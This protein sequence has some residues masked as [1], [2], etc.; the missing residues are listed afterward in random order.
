VKKIF[1][2]LGIVL[3]GLIGLIVLVV[4]GLYIKTK[5]AFSQTYEVKVESVSVPTDAESIAR[6]QHIVTFLCMECHGDNLGGKPDFLSLPNIITVNTPNL[7]SGKGGIGSGFTDE[8]WVRVLRHGVKPDGTSIF[9]MPAQDF[10]YLNDQDLSAL[11][12]YAKS[13]P[14]VESQVEL[15]H[16]EITFMGKVMYGAG[17]FGNLARASAIDQTHRPVLPEPGLN[18]EYGKY[19]VDVNGCRDCHGAQLSGGKTGDPDSPLT[20]N[21]T[22]GGELIAWKEADFIN[23]LRTGV[24][25][26]GHKLNPKFMPWN[27][28]G[29]MSDDELK[30]IF[31]YLQTLPK[32]PT[33]TASV[34]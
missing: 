33:S 12:A 31:M 14:P 18:P 26:S 34:E 30:A 4:L 15:P 19:L 22:P 21:L 27:Y 1:K 16:Y 28:K 9:I 20:P 32:L 23:A 13:V 11:I 6:G 5:N 24:A 8:D 3:A 2:W 7:T 25:L 10:Y 29:K 17:L